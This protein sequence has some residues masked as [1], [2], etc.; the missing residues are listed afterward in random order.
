MNYYIVGAVVVTL[1]V[2][3]GMIV[4]IVTYDTDDPVRLSPVTDEEEMNKRHDIFST[5]RPAV[6]A[7]NWDEFVK[8]IRSMPD[9]GK[10]S[11]SE[12]K[13]FWNDLRAGKI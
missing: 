3:V 2:L 4:A 5:V 6:A 11:D 13:L 9:G 7:E 1:A 8:I 12:L 10:I